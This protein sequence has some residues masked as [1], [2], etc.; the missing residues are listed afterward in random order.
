M[1]VQ[2]VSWKIAI[3]RAVHGS[4]VDSCSIDDLLAEYDRMRARIVVVKHEDGTLRRMSEL[5]LRLA[6][7]GSRS[8]CA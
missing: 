3:V 2:A 4:T 1:E 6:C 7:T 5:Y 8:L